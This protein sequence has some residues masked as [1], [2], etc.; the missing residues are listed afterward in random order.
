[1]KRL[2]LVSALVAAVAPLAVRAEDK[3]PDPD[4]TLTGNAGLFSDYRFRGYTQTGYRPAFQGGFDFSHKS[5]FYIGNWNSN[6]EQGLYNGASLE[7]DLYGGYKTTFGP[8]GLDVGYYHYLYPNSGALGTTTVKNGEIYVGGSAGPVSAK[9]YYAVTKFF[10]IGAPPSYADVDTKG[11]WYFDLSGSYEVIPSLTV[12]AHYGY[13][14]IKNGKQAGLIDDKVS[15]YRAGVAYDL[16]GW[17]LAA[18]IVG[19]SKKD[20]F[21][22]AHSGFT[23]GA[24]KAGVVLSVSKTF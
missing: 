23:E 3:K 8:V 17:S 14:S 10:S 21:T 15:D 22:T 16:S 19:T 18:N 7:M 5:G 9:V 24:G 11:S 4:Y 6:V 13:Q 1:M 12:S 20:L 2:I